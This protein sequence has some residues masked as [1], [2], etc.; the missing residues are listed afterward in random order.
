VTAI[1]QRI[2][3]CSEEDLRIVIDGADSR[4]V[5]PQ[6]KHAAQ[7]ET[8][9][10]L[11][12]IYDRFEWLLETQ[13]NFHALL[14]DCVVDSENFFLHVDVSPIKLPNPAE[15][16]DLFLASVSGEEPSRRFLGGKGATE[17]KARRN[18]LHGKWL[19]H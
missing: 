16:Y 17:E 15:V 6:E 2:W 9:Q 5:L 11:F 13:A 14:F 4:A 12:V 19:K 10:Y 7:K 3:G 8:P 1:L 18:E